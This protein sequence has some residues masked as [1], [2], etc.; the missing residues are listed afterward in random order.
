MVKEKKKHRYGAFLRLYGPRGKHTGAVMILTHA[1]EPDSPEDFYY[2]L[3]LEHTMRRNHH[4]GM[5]VQLRV[6]VMQ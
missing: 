4:A 6:K 1:P 5:R 2:E 3:E